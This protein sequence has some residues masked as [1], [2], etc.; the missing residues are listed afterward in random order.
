MSIF[1]CNFTTGACCPSFFTLHPFY[2]LSFQCGGFA[3]LYCMFFLWFTRSDS[4]RFVLKILLMKTGTTIHFSEWGKSLAQN[5]LINRKNSFHCQWK[6]QGLFSSGLLPFL[7]IFRQIFLRANFFF[8]LSCSS[9][10]W[11]ERLFVSQLVSCP[12]T[13]FLSIWP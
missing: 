13:F 6:V 2:T 7:L 8:L 11:W 10:A 5:R 4:K 1:S 9:N 12:A 3:T